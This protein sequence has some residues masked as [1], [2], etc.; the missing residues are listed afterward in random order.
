MMHNLVIFVPTVQLPPAFVL[1]CFTTFLSTRVA[2]SKKG[3]GLA[4]VSDRKI[5]GMGF[6][7]GKIQVF[8]TCFEFTFLAPTPNGC[9]KKGTKKR[10]FKFAGFLAVFC[11]FAYFV[12]LRSVILVNEALN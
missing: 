6:P 1:F 10:K 5:T 8:V 7:A 12:G 11:S 9:H 4:A 2:C 3:H